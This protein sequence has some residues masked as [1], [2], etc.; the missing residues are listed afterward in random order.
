MIE[1]ELQDA[2][3]EEVQA[4]QDGG[5]GSGASLIDPSSEH[6]SQQAGMS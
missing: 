2:V 6:G 5:N 3:Q 4:R 1:D